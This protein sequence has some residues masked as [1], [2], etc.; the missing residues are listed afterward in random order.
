MSPRCRHELNEAGLPPNAERA[1][2]RREHDR[3]ACYHGHCSGKQ[4]RCCITLAG[5]AW[6]FVQPVTP[7]AWRWILVIAGIIFVLVSAQD[8]RDMEGDR[9]IGRRTVPLVFGEQP[10]RIGLAVGF[11][12]LPFVVHSWLITPLD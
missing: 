7:L 12:L 3:S 11:A 6:T 9:H 10:T 1:R 5:A 2:L 8:L 4:S